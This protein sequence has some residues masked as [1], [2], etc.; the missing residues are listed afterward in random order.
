[1]S[2]IDIGVRDTLTEIAIY[3]DGTVGLKIR[4][5]GTN[6][7]VRVILSRQ[8]AERLAKAL[9]EWQARQEKD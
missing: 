2:K 8:D 1:M 6:T 3:Q 7:P 9:A 5:P 4:R